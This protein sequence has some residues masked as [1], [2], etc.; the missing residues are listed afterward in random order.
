MPVVMSQVIRGTTELYDQVGFVE[1]WVGYV[2]LAGETPVGSCGF[3]SPPIN[4]RV[5][6][7]YYTFPDHEGK[8]YASAMAATLVSLAQ[9]H[10]PFVAVAAQ[11]LPARNASHRILEKLG[12]VHVETVEHPEDGVVWEWRLPTPSG[13]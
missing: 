4:G 8:G 3:K 7:A 2:A 6:I 11:T 13:A 9:R 5:E 12:F 1:P 10:A